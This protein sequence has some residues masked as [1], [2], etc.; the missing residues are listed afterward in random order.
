[1]RRSG[2]RT[3]WF[4]RQRN[5]RFWN[6]HR[7]HRVVNSTVYE[8]ITRSTVYTEECYDITG[9][10]F[11][12]IFHL[13]RVHTYKT[14]NLELLLCTS[15]VEFFT[16]LNFTLVNAGICKLTILTIIKFETKCNTRLVIN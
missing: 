12:D 3:L 1:M 4:N 6:E 9:T 14:S 7:S 11:V 8:C 10:T 16:L 5:Y 13:C 2:C 15:I